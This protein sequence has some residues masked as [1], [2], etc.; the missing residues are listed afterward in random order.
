MLDRFLEWVAQL[1]ELA[2]YI[3]LMALSALEN[4]FPPVPAD[5]TVP[6]TDVYASAAAHRALAER[7]RVRAALRRYGE[8]GITHFVLSDTPYKRETARVGDALIGAPDAEPLV[9]SPVREG[10]ARASG[11]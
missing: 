8:L 3:V 1:P 5:A 6:V 7:D 9:L 10:T 4:V 11:A 2:V